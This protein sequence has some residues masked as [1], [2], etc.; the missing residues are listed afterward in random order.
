MTDTFVSKYFG[1][2]FLHPDAVF[3][4]QMLRPELQDAD[5]FADSVDTIAATHTRVARAFHQDGTISLAVPPLRALLEIMAD[6][7]SAEGWTLRSEPFRA[8]F[9]RESVLSS[10]WYAERL[11]ARQTAA[12]TLARSGLTAMER[13][14][15]TPGNDEPTSRLGLHDRVEAARAETEFVATATYRDQLVGTLGNTPLG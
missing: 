11:D 3:T 15:S 12:A 9:T 8:S 6:G 7:V 10:S 2:I 5:I 1:R 13:F 14:V 4:A